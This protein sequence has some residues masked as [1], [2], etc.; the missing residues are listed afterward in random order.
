MYLIFLFSD[1]LDI[2]ST[3][4]TALNKTTSNEKASFAC[5]KV[6]QELGIGASQIPATLNLTVTVNTR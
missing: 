5:G 1:S 6:T 2:Q 3:I 4:I